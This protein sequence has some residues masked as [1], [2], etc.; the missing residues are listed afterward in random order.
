MVFLLFR[1]FIIIFKEE[2]DMEKLEIEGF[3]DLGNL[4]IEFKPITVLTGPSGSGKS[5]VM[6]LRYFF[7]GLFYS[8]QDHL[9][10]FRPPEA[11]KQII[12][13][14]FLTNFPVFSE[15][16]ISFKII[17]SLGKFNITISRNLESEFILNIK[18]NDEFDSFIKDFLN[19]KDAEIRSRNELTEV[20]QFETIHDFISKLNIEYDKRIEK[21]IQLTELSSNLFIPAEREYFNSQFTVNNFNVLHEASI[22]GRIKKEFNTMI[23][24]IVLQQSLD[25]LYVEVRN[26]SELI[27]NINGG[28]ITIFENEIYLTSSNVKYS[29]YFGSSGQKSTTY[30]IILLAK[31]YN[32]YKSINSGITLY[33]E[34]PEAHLFP[35][36]QYELIKL[37][38]LIYNNI[39]NCQIILSTHSN[40]MMTALNNF[41]IAGT[42]LKNNPGTE[43]RINDI[44]KVNSSVNIENVAAWYLND[45]TSNNMIE[46]DLINFEGLDT[47]GEQIINDF[48][49]IL[50]LYDS[51]K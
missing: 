17:Y 16:A 33:I 1:E 32:I 39:K 35:N 12:E 30:L 26:V 15:T 23:Q 22:E 5:L 13:G 25:E 18:F 36:Q 44:L 8:I 45:K 43:D 49:A 7:K 24:Q 47:A 10:N 2:L 3:A 20:A 29:I 46:N 48:N 50:D 21:Y 11:L 27:T 6:K 31:I 9:T 42:V 34:E 40:Y 4:E 37:I 14:V 51:E 38:C 19:Y 41:I 28:H